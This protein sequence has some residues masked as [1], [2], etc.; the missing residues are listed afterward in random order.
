MTPRKY[1]PYIPALGKMIAALVAV[2][3]ISWTMLSAAE[4]A[5]QRLVID[6]CVS[7]GQFTIKEQVF[8]CSPVTQDPAP[9]SPESLI[10]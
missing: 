5:T 8:L 10:P 3:A 6:K 2:A 1:H 7:A 4:S 9:T